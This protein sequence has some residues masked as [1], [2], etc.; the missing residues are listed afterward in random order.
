MSQST[1]QPWEIEYIYPVGPG[2]QPYGEGDRMMEG[3]GGFRLEDLIIMQAR[4]E[5]GSLACV[6]VPTDNVRAWFRG[7]I[8]GEDAYRAYE[9]LRTFLEEPAGCFFR[10][11]AGKP[12]QNAPCLDR[13]LT[14]HVDGSPSQPHSLAFFPRGSEPENSPLG[15]P[16]LHTCQS[17]SSSDFGL[18]AKK[19]SATLTPR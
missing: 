5:G 14:R 8:G 18:R 7:W 10:M 9:Y 19:E 17:C 1:R 13:V 6:S 11:F 3:E 12:E 16:L 4:R 2:S 15:S